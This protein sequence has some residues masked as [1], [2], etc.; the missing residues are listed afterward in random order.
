M[1]RG[2]TEGRQARKTGERGA[3]GLAPGEWRR[4]TER[5]TAAGRE[6]GESRQTEKKEIYKYL[7][8]RREKNAAETRK[9]VQVCVYTY[10]LI[11]WRVGCLLHFL[12]YI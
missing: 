3:D 6:Q 7:R 9:S 12:L 11:S 5:S 8:E 10:H 1:E 2:Q 4:G